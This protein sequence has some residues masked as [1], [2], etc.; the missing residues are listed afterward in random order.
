MQCLSSP[1]CGVGHR[2]HDESCQAAVTSGSLTCVGIV[3]CG[4]ACS[5]PTCIDNCYLSGT[6]AAQN[7]Y[8]QL[9]VCVAEACPQSGGGICDT[10]SSSYNATNCQN[11]INNAPE[12]SCPGQTST[13]E[14][15]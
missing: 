7:A 10:T 15:T 1:G 12:F 14:S 8:L 2:C 6:L 4:A 5:T 13:C 3:N 9:D 11:C